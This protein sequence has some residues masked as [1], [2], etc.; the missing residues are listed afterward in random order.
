MLKHYL[1]AM[2]VG[3]A[4]LASAVPSQAQEHVSGTRAAAIH[5]CSVAA[6]RYP[7]TTW[8]SLEFEIYRACMARHGQA[9]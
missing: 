2:L 5:E 3:A 8:S 6:G 1:T 4:M 7:E 9:E